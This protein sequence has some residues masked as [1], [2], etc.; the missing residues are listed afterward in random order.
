MKMFF[1]TLGTETNTFSPMPTGWN[2][3]NDFLLIHNDEPIRGPMD[4]VA[5][6][7][8]I[9]EQ[10]EWEISRGLLAYAMPAGVTPTPVYESLRDELI[11][12]LEAAMPVDGVS[13]LL[14]GAMVAGEY[15]DCEGDILAH[16]RRV[17]GPDIPVGAV[18][19]LHVNL[20]DQM[21]K[22]ATVLV[23]YKEY[24]HTDINQRLEDLFHI[25]ADTA[26]GKVQPV[27][28]S[29]EAPMIG[30]YHTTR[31][32]MR[33]FVRE[34][35][36]LE[37]QDAVLNVWLAHCF[38]WSDVS[39]IGARSV[40]VTDNNPVLG[41]EIAEKM[42]RKFFE[43]RSEVLSR[44][45]TINNCLDKALAANKGPITI[46]DTSDNAGGGAPS[47]ST[48]FLAEMI[49]RN[50]DNAGIAT[51][52]DPAAVSI[53][54]DA[55][56]GAS[57]SLRIGGKLGPTSGDPVDATATVIGLADEVVQELGGM[58]MSM[59]RCAAIKVQLKEK[60]KQTDAL[61]NGI[62][63]I[64]SQLRCQPVAPN[65]FTDLGIDPMKKKILVVKSYQHF[66]AGFAP[67][68][69]EILYAGDKG[70][71]QSDMTTIPY[72]SVDTERFWPFV[73][74]PFSKQM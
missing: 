22:E 63:V 1:A 24:P 4:P 50:I 12:D 60:Q 30:M 31:E 66:Y 55:G 32:P 36:N 9:A 62:D 61:D 6:L 34:M 27:M 67:I 13:L 65:I 16:V 5:F 19:D 48:F 40:V 69:E 74:N 29:F 42:G 71:L 14:H 58:K 44:P 15:D 46:A 49:A 28:S 38:P 35:E 7:S 26:E 57:L 52:W 10:R 54:E 18:L 11:A 25:I 39:F 2:V 41:D 72:N 51:I 70:T 64:L 73:E 3:W 20:S 59:G 21:L 53:C 56:I 8:P 33:S 23:G 43:I 68:S 17:V 47:D 37:K 45:D